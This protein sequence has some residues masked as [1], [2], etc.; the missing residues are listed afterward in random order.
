M[1]HQV[2]LAQSLADSDTSNSEKLKACMVTLT[3]MGKDVGSY[4]EVIRTLSDELKGALYQGSVAQGLDEYHGCILQRFESLMETCAEKEQQIIKMSHQLERMALPQDRFF[5]E[6]VVPKEFHDKVVED[7]E[8]K[9]GLLSTA[10]GRETFAMEPEEDAKRC[11][12]PL[13]KP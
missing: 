4:S 2:T 7:K 5:T 9:L 11:L 6:M 8:E 1:G 3:E 13:L 12:Q 10:V